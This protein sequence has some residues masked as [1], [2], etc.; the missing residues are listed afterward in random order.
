MLDL[1]AEWSIRSLPHWEKCVPRSELLPLF[2]MKGLAL[3][4]HK[5]Y[6]TDIMLDHTQV[7][8]IKW[9]WIPVE[10]PSKTNP[11]CP[12]I[13]LPQ[14]LCPGSQ[15]IHEGKRAVWRLLTHSFSRLETIPWFPCLCSLFTTISCQ[16]S[17][18]KF[19]YLMRLGSPKG[20]LLDCCSCRIPPIQGPRI[21]GEVHNFPVIS[22]T[23][24]YGETT[25]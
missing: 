13:S 2:P 22:N 4:Y 9:L 12:Y 25:T 17:V 23:S 1:M 11:S 6:M 21:W 15:A 8:R 10:P 19:L 14:V 18:F 24:F 16:N 5:L 7:D 20:C 3:F